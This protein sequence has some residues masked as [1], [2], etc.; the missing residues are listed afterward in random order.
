MT[1][2]V[3]RGAAVAAWLWPL[4]AL[5][6]GPPPEEG[7]AAVAADH[8]LASACG[9]EVLER[10]G[11]AVDAAVAAALCAGVV[12]P[13]GSGLGGGGFALVHL[14]DGPTVSLDFREVAPAAAARDMFVGE[15]GQVIDGLS[16]AGGLAV[17]V[18]GE[19]RG[20]AHLHAT[21]GELPLRTVVRPAIRLAARGFPVGVHLSRSVVRSKAEQ[22]HAATGDPPAGAS[23]RRPALAASLRAFAARGG[24]ALSEGRRAQALVE[25]ARAGG[26]VLTVEDLGAYVPIER[27]VLTGVFRG[28]TVET[29]APPSSG[30]IALLQVLRALDDD[31]LAGLGHNSSAYLHR[32]TEAFKHAF[33]DRAHALGDPSFVDVPVRDLLDEARIE[34][35]RQAFDP[36]RTQPTEA[37]GDLIAPPRDAGTQHISV[38]DADGGAV[39][40]TTTINTSFGSGLWPESLGYPLNNEMDDFSAQPGTPNAYGLVGSEA[41]AIM[42][43]KR[44]L[45]SMTPTLVRD[46]AGEVVLVVGASGGPTIIT[47]TIQVILNVVVF[48]MDPAAAVAAPRIHAQW[49]PDVVFLEP[50]L[51]EDVRSALRARG[52]ELVVM[53]A[54]SAASAVSRRDGAAVVEAGSDPRKGGRPAAL[55]AAGSSGRAPRADAP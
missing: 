55:P 24:E 33:A 4:S 29:M 12:Q 18:P 37:Y 21:W 15:D 36:A 31:A 17:A 25:A 20:L 43:G 13:A 16:R 14:P 22:V 32:L 27:P 40:L 23:W 50:E 44:P 10:G 49:I 6:A 51:P 34:A 9:A 2:F 46:A 7:R 3:R 47:S 11:N 19:P 54:F 53:P 30:G 1:P 48:G 26:G 41:N 45:S 38:L 5:A 8:A 52:H 35:I 28:L 42:Q 39:A